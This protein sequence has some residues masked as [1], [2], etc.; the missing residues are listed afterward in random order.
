MVM[1]INA[2]TTCVVDDDDDYHDDVGVC[3]ECC[4]MRRVARISM[5]TPALVDHDDDDE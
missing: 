3:V 2:A 1:N 5:P 4:P